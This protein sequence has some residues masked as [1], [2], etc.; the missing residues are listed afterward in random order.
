MLLLVPLTALHAADARATALPSLLIEAFARGWQKEWFTYHLDDNW[1][2]KTH[3]LYDP[4]WQAPVGAKLALEV[5]AVG[6]NRLVIGL[7]DS[8]PKSR[9]QAARRGKASCCK[10]AIFT[11]PSAP[12]KRIEKAFANCAS[13]L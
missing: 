1:A 2:G 11:T 9:R 4:Q 3:K 10:R 12:R 7:D 8:P 6:A 13:A 5:R